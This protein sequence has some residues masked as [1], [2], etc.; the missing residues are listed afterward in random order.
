MASAAILLTACSLRPRIN[1]GDTGQPILDGW[2]RQEAAE[3]WLASMLTDEYIGVFNGTGQWLTPDSL[4]H[5]TQG[6]V[7]VE[8]PVHEGNPEPRWNVT[9]RQPETGGFITFRDSAAVL[10]SVTG[11][12]VRA[13]GLV[14]YHFV[15]GMYPDSGDSIVYVQNRGKGIFTVFYMRRVRK[16]NRADDSWSWAPHGDPNWYPLLVSV[17]PGGDSLLVSRGLKPIE[18]FVDEKLIDKH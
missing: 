7:Q 4:A 18:T 2:T 10:P 14:S 12:T 13:D 5:L 1:G 3:Y 11:D 15:D 6:H 9:Y 8:L 16:R 17:Y